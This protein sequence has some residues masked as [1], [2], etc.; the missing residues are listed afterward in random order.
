[1]VVAAVATVP[2]LGGHHGAHLHVHVVGGSTRVALFALRVGGA[3]NLHVAEIAL[4]IHNELVSLCMC[5]NKGNKE[6]TDN[7]IHWK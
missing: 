1:M 3:R 6:M 5:T 2:V 4:H 7:F